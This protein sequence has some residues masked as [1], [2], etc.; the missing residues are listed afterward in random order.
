MW[1]KRHC[2]RFSRG[3]KGSSVDNWHPPPHS[4]SIT[5]PY[6]HQLTGIRI[7]NISTRSTRHLNPTNNP[8]CL[9]IQAWGPSYVDLACLLPRPSHGCRSAS[10]FQV[11]S[12]TNNRFSPSLNFLVIWTCPWKFLKSLGFINHLK[13]KLFFKFDKSRILLRNRI[14]F[15]EE[16]I[17]L[18]K[19]S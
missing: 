16:T 17:F 18:R 14:F 4:I 19:A 1:F 7:S 10:Y 6:L 9:T 11:W 13:K 15:S 5:L 3:T 12:L 8:A 2:L